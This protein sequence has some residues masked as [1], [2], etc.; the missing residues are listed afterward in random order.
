MRVIYEAL[1]G[2]QFDNEWECYNYEFILK[3]KEMFNIEF[4]DEKDNLYKITETDDPCIVD[5]IYQYTEKVKIHNERELSDLMA[6]SEDYGWCEFED[7]ITSPGFWIRRTD[8]LGNPNWEKI[9]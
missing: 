2:K 9:S 1:D 4:F 5:K 3:H 8:E 6:L 7:Y